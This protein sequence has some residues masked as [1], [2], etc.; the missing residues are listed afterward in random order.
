M[1]NN[2]FLH[3]CRVPS[4][5]DDSSWFKRIQIEKK[6]CRSHHKFSFIIPS[7]YNFQLRCNLTGQSG[8]VGILLN[9]SWVESEF[10]P[11]CANLS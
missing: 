2:S 11:S 10:V 3:F 4:L 8:V 6:Y 9:M 1:R 5:F 7:Q